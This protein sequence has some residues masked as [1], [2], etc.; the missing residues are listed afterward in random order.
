MIIIQILAKTTPEIETFQRK[1]WKY[2]DMERYGETLEWKRETKMLTATENNKLLGV[3]E[4]IMESGVMSID[5]LIV[6]HD[7][8]GKGIGTNLM[9][10]AESLARKNKLHKIHLTTGKNWN[11]TKFYETL[12]Y[13]KTGELLNHYDGQD[14]VEYS[15]FLK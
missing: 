4:L 3:L 11:A 8:Q 1:E 12:G 15:K 5:N 14:H 9:Q 2:D 7:K 10:T 13:K 6:R